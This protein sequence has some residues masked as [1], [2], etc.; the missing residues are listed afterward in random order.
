MHWLSP[1]WTSMEGHLGEERAASRS[2]DE[3][4]LRRADAVAGKGGAILRHQR[5]RHAAAASLWR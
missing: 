3:P 4:D 2:E 1:L 5:Y